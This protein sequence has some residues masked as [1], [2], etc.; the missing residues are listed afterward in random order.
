MAYYYVK[1]DK[2]TEIYFNEYDKTTT[3]ITANTNLKN[4]LL[5]YAEKYPSLCKCI[6][7]D[8]GTVEYE[9]Q[10]DR[11]SIRLLPPCTETRKS[12][13]RKL[14]EKINKVGDIMWAKQKQMRCLFIK[15]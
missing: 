10:K 5:S 2:R 13:A 9:I 12:T 15:I 1:R 4:R 14:M 6:S 7:E 8:E 3:V 11:L